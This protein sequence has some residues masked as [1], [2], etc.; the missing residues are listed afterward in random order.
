MHER[1]DVI[2]LAGAAQVSRQLPAPRRLAR[3]SR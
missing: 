3:G 1:Y 2:E